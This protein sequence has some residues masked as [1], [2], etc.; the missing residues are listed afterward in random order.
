M[1]RPALRRPVRPAAVLLVTSCLLATSACGVLLPGSEPVRDEA[2]AITEADDAADVFSIAVGDCTDDA[3]DASSTEAEEISTVAVVPCGEPHDNEVYAS[4]L[5]DD[6][7]YPGLEVVEA[8][9][10]ERCLGEFEGFVGAA[11]EESAY[12]YWPMYPTAE[13]WATGDREILCLV[14]HGELEKV[15]GTLKAIG[16]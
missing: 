13:S 7:D 8:E 4:V 3:E 11:Y 6:G 14:Y 10:D 2:G 12:D 15:T 1:S 9:A 5:L 16:G